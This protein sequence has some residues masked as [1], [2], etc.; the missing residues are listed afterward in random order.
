MVQQISLALQNVAGGKLFTEVGRAPARFPA[1]VARPRGVPPEKPCWAK[2]GAR[3]AGHRC[4]FVVVNKEPK[5]RKYDCLRASV[6]AVV[7]VLFMKQ[8]ICR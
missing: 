8:Y 4:D 2:S 5:L 3:A 1:L 7:S 6:A